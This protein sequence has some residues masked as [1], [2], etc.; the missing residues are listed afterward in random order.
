MT[1]SWDKNCFCFLS[2]PAA[3]FL[4]QNWQL[5]GQSKHRVRNPF[6]PYC[7]ESYKINVYSYL[8]ALGSHR[9][10]FEFTHFKMSFSS[11]L[12]TSKFWELFTSH[13]LY[14]KKHTRTDEK[15]MFLK[16]PVRDCPV[17]IQWVDSFYT[18]PSIK[19]FPST[20]LP[21]PPVLCCIF[22]SK[23]LPMPVINPAMFSI[24]NTGASSCLSSQEL[25]LTT[26]L[27]LSLG[28]I[29]R[30]SLFSQ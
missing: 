20:Q 25:Q 30:P 7:Q 1:V 8:Y 16:Y 13:V 6:W 21:N 5:K 3:F 24:Q 22:C 2:F 18:I 26:A 19:P 29:C 23:S 11:S 9:F 28:K 14:F 4:C 10:P 17:T 15:L 12:G 27:T